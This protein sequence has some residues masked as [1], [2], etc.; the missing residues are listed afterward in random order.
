ASPFVSHKGARALMRNPHCQIHLFVRRSD[1]SGVPRWDDEPLVV[2]PGRVVHVDR[3]ARASDVS[4]A[5][6]AIQIM[7]TVMISRI[8]VECL[9]GCRLRVNGMLAPS[10][11]TARA[12]D[13]I[14]PGDAHGEPWRVHVSVYRAAV[15][16]AAGD[17]LSG[18]ECPLCFGRFSAE[19][20]VFRCGCGS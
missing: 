14:T 8:A 13:E 4:V 2:E 17:E 15:I 19:T 3:D 18:R 11:A 16:G 5:S 20:R 9:R 1:D 6:V 10:L 7:P 12:G